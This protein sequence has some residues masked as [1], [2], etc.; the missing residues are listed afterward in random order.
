MY[1]V[2]G[3]G[4]G[5]RHFYQVDSLAEYALG[6]VGTTICRDKSLLSLSGKVL[7]LLLVSLIHSLVC[8]VCIGAPFDIESLLLL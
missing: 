4:S 6:Y 1:R 7:F 5:V 2:L 3:M 8:E